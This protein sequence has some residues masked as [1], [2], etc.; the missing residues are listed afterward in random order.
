MRGS[1]TPLTFD[2]LQ[3][4]E[5]TLWSM[6]PRGQGANAVDQK[7]IQNI[8]EHVDNQ[9]HS[10]LITAGAPQQNIDDYHAARQDWHLWKNTVGEL[11]PRGQA[12]GTEVADALYNKGIAKNPDQALYFARMVSAADKLNPGT[13]QK[14]ANGFLEHFLQENR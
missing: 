14:F 2:D 10:T 9:L 3:K 5:D 1:K 8:G 4:F 12:F 13:R 6:Y 7:L 11:N